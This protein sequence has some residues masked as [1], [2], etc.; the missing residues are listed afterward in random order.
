MDTATLADILGPAALRDY[1]GATETE[2]AH[3]R[4]WAPTLATLDDQ[5]FLGACKD[6]IAAGVASE[7]V[8]ATA[9][10]PYIKAYACM[11]EA[12]RRQQ[13]AGH[14]AGCGGDDIYQRALDEVRQ[15]FGFTSST[16]TACTCGN[17]TGE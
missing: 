1:E 2:Q 13:I 16:P 14:E 8:R 12:R 15:G 17:G 3:I 9:P 10:E 4:S 6:A 5:A 11:H 7:S